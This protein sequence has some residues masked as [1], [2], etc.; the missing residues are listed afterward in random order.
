VLKYILQQ[1]RKCRFKKGETMKTKKNKVKNCIA[2]L[3]ASALLA[4]TVLSLAGCSNPTGP[5]PSPEKPEE[6]EENQ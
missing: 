3:L 4:G 2:C 1:R 5:E 6:Q